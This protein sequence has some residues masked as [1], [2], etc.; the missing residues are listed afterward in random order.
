MSDRQGGWRGRDRKPSAGAKRGGW[1]HLGGRTF[2]SSDWTE[3]F[4]AGGWR[5]RTVTN[6]RE[7]TWQTHSRFAVF[8]PR[9]PGPLDYYNVED[10]RKTQTAKHYGLK[11]MFNNSHSY[12]YKV[13]LKDKCCRGWSVRS[14][15]RR[16]TTSSNPIM[17]LLFTW[18][19]VQRSA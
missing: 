4:I 16:S 15:K 18:H 2:C 10:M 8:S 19:T 3:G 1:R 5:V 6:V 13:F 17:W 12:T 11:N 7:E 14:D 9:I